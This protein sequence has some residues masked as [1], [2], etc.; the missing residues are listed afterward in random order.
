MKTINSFRGDNNKKQESLIECP[1][2]L[3]KQNFK[4][5]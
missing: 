4:I 3:K 2:T 1:T 5:S